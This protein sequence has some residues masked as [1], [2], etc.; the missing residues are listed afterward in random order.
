MDPKVVVALHDAFKKAL[1]E[2]VYK[3]A[4]EKFDQEL[5][6]LSTADY[7]KHAADQIAEAKRLVEDLGLKKK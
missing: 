3:A 7:N 4:L 2:P 6:Y 5:A 1:D